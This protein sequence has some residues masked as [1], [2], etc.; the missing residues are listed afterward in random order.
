MMVAEL[1]KLLQEL[2][3]DSKVTIPHFY[4]L[5]TGG[6]RQKSCDILSV[7]P[8]Y[9]QD[10]NKIIDYIIIPNLKYEDIE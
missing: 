5:K 10:T 6:L 4:K 2:P 3:Q 8:C 1:I 9:D 7:D